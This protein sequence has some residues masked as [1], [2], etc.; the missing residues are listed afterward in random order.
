MKGN[1]CG[2]PR[3]RK[4][5]PR[6]PS[7]V[8]PQQRKCPKRKGWRQMKT[9]GHHHRHPSNV[10]PQLRECTQR[11]GWRR[12][13]KM[14]HRPQKGFTPHWWWGNVAAAREEEGGEAPRRT[15]PPALVPCAETQR[16]KRTWLA[17]L[18]DLLT[19]LPERITAYF[20]KKI[21]LKKDI[22]FSRFLKLLIRL[23]NK[24][25]TYERKKWAITSSWRKTTSM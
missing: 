22:I 11:K 10:T 6:L 5:A 20:T 25:G 7:V 18:D 9:M 15:I 12:M 3:R 8:A 4:L 2:F 21:C 17:N 16:M 19:T 1:K 14:G 13:K 23:Y 24:G